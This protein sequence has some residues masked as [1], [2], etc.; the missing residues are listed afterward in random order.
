MRDVLASEDVG[1]P[2]GCRFGFVASPNSANVP[3]QSQSM[4]HT[5]VLGAGIFPSPGRHDSAQPRKLFWVLVCSPGSVSTVLQCLTAE[6]ELREVGAPG[7]GWSRSIWANEGQRPSEVLFHNQLSQGSPTAAL[8]TCPGVSTASHC[9]PPAHMHHWMQT[10][11][12]VPAASY[13]WCT[14]QTQGMNDSAF[15][16]WVT[17]N[18]PPTLPRPPR[19]HRVRTV[20]VPPG[21]W[22]VCRPWGQRR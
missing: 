14:K 12:E 17:P 20:V 19:A 6:Q 5:H 11:E 1:A 2:R 10:W 15:S 3:E 16:S 9:L 13:G 18:S 8:A 21:W 22:V 7:H 4:K